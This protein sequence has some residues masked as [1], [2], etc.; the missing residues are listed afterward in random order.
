MAFWGAP[1]DVAD[2]ALRA[3]KAALKCQARLAELREDW[4]AAGCPQIH[5]R[6]GINTG[7]VVVGNIGSE[8]RMNY[9]VIGDS[10]NVASRLE[11][12]CKGFKLD[13]LI[14]QR[15][16]EL[17][18]TAIVARPLGRLAVRGKEDAILVYAL[19]ALRDEAT[20]VQLK[21]EALGEEAI[22]AYLAR[23]F[24][25]AAAACRKLLKLLPG[26]VSATELLARARD[27]AK[28]P[29]PHR[30]EALLTND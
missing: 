17:A 15:T 13:I 3:C 16:R 1:Q 12:E 23:D 4:S 21:A 18:G 27:A 9:T 25:P 30:G 6:I 11:G 26:D 14:G 28:S 20:P 29:V 22:A 7:E 5:A 8:Q 19:V 2:H 10:V 24:R